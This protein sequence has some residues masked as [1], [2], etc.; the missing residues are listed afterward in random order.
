MLSASLDKLRPVAALLAILAPAPAAA[1]VI[2]EIRVDVP[3][4][5]GYTIGDKV[6]HVMHLRVKDPYRLDQSTMPEVGRVNRWLEITRAEAEVDYGERSTG[7]RIVVEYQ[8]FNAPREST[9]VTIPQLELLVTGTATAIPVFLPEWT[10]GIAPITDSEAQQSFSLRPD[11]PPQPIPVAG[12]GIRFSIWALVLIGL[13]GFLA[14]RRFVAPRLDRARY[15][16][17][18]ALLK[19]KKLK[20]SSSDRNNYRQALKAFHAAVNAT[21]GRVV[22]AGDLDDFLAANPRYAALAAELSAVYARSQQLF[23]K[24]SAPTLPDTSLEELIALCRR[25]RA[26][27]RSAA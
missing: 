14:Y 15:P 26:L 19:L 11:R 5:F 3:R 20:R 21:A 8:I 9:S 1:Q 24:K 18:R 2:S 13:L 12:R 27:E 25:C 16:F 6:E 10:F 7:Y 17:A 4:D 23:F 22:L